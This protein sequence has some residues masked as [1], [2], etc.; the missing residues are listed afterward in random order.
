MSKKRMAKRQTVR[1]P[2]SWLDEDGF[3]GRPRSTSERK[4]LKELDRQLQRFLARAAGL[5]SAATGG[6]YA[7]DADVALAAEDL[8]RETLLLRTQ[9]RESL[10]NRNAALDELVES[11][12]DSW[13]QLRESYDELRQ[14]SRPSESLAPRRE[15]FDDEEDY[16]S[17]DLYFDDEDLNFLTTRNARS[18]RIHRPRIGPKR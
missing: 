6:D 16:D 5:E 15:E 3:S 7:E 12:E 13:R 4:Y 10:I 8:Y 11:F 1:H 9:I 14:R 18:G 17:Y 2:D